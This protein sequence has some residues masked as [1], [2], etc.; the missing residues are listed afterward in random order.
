MAKTFKFPKSMG[1]CADRLY[2]IRA[3]RLAEQKKVEELEAEERALKAHIIDNLPKSQLTGASG[4]IA[5]VKIVTKTVPQ[6]ADIDKFYGYI[7]KTGRTDLL[8]K[9]LNETAIN[10]IL[11]S[12]KNAVVP[13]ITTFDAKGVSLTKV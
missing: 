8:Q 4:K 12:K 3:R 5:N 6:I 13:G 9:R 1:V 10:E 2:E 7:R 11:E